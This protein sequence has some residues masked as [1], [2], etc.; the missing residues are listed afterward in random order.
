[1]R[2]DLRE[3]ARSVG[4]YRSLEELDFT[5]NEVENHWEDSKH[6]DIICLPS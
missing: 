4:S 3:V 5:L 2:W 1:M 6:R